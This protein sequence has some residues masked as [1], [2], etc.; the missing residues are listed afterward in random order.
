MGFGQLSTLIMEHAVNKEVYEATQMHRFK[1][2]GLSTTY[3]ADNKVTDSAA[4]G[5][6]L[7]TGEKRT[8]MYWD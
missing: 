1:H 4:G 2:M 8:T 5:T 7:A 3:S 6:A